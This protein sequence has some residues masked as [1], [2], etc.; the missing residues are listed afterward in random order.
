MENLRPNLLVKAMMHEFYRF[1]GEA[2]ILQSSNAEFSDKFSKEIDKLPKEEIVGREYEKIRRSL[3]V[4]AFICP[5]TK[6]I[7]QE[8]VVAADDYTYEKRAIEDWF[9]KS[10][11]SPQTGK[12][13][14]HKNL[15]PNH[16]TKAMIDL[17][18]QEQQEWKNLRGAEQ[19]F[20]YLFAPKIQ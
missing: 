10:D 1:E 19:K 14:P 5:L 3:N 8:P 12:K 16:A 6:S 18:K 13:F 20:L 15:L 9:T 17:F 7:F 4:E 11:V 2:K